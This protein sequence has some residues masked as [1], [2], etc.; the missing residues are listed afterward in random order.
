[1]DGT[2]ALQRAGMRAAEMLASRWAPLAIALAGIFVFSFA[3]GSWNETAGVHDEMS[4]LFQAKLFASGRWT[5]P[6]PPIP[7]FFEQWHLFVVPRYASKYPP[8]HALLMVPG[9]WLGLPG[10]M[11]V[12][13][14]A[15]AGA[16]VFSIARRL[17]NGVVA[18]GS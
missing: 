5:A 6:P 17:V 16:L 2:N 18:F 7:E 4:Y 3:W 13:I 11:P 9:I 15:V 10:L 1:M 12:V 14:G 8:G